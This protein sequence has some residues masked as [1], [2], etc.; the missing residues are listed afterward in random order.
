[1]PG[2]GGPAGVGKPQDGGAAT[3]TQLTGPADQCGELLS[4]FPHGC[5]DELGGKACCH[6]IEEF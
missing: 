1:M 2:S 6:D 3:F 4:D 5:Q